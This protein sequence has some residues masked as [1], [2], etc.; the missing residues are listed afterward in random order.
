MNK[1]TVRNLSFWIFVLFLYFT[2]FVIVMVI[3]FLNI[4]PLWIF[5]VLLIWTIAIHKS[6][7]E[8]KITKSL[9]K[10]FGYW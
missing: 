7:L 4:N 5:P 6:N 10:H 1:T 3:T 8:W 9:L 2:L